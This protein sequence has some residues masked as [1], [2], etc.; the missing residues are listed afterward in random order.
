MPVPTLMCFNPRPHTRGDSPHGLPLWLCSVSIH[1]PTRGATQIDLPLKSITLFQST[2]P[3][4]G[5]R[6]V[7]AVNRECIVSIHA[8]ARGATSNSAVSSMTERMFQSTPPRGGRL[9]RTRSKSTTLSFNPRPR[10]G[11]DIITT[12]GLITQLAVSIHAPARGATFALPEFDRLG[13]FQ[14]TPPRGGRPSC[15]RVSIRH[16]MFQST[17]P[18]G[19]RHQRAFI[20]GSFSSF[21]PRP[22][23]GGDVQVLLPM[24]TLNVSIHA[25]AR[26][27]TRAVNCSRTFWEFQSTPPRGG[28]PLLPHSCKTGCVSIHAPARGAT[29]TVQVSFR[30]ILVSIHAPAR[31]AT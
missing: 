11:G 15:G 7:R 26:G 30:L 31:G 13:K 22:R 6:S 10:A 19:G 2:L 17:P 3:R 29:F 5:R 25:P 12:I 4:G 16:L 27:A 8:P 1:A 28:R 9:N 20:S 23:A 14:S 24:F 18:R 21:N